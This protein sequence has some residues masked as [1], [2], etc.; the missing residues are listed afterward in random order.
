MNVSKKLIIGF[1][2]AILIFLSLVV[3]K[4]VSASTVT[5]SAGPG[6]AIYDQYGNSL[7][8]AWSIWLNQGVTKSFTITPDTGYAIFSVTGCGG[9]LSGNTYTIGPLS[10]DCSVYASFTPVF[11]IT[12]SA[13]TGGTISPSGVV[14]VNYGAQQTFTV[15]ANT[16]YTYTSVTGCGGT[17]FTNIF[18]TGQITANCAVTATFTPIQYSYNTYV[19]S[20]GG[21]IYPSG[22]QAAYGA[23]LSLIVTPATGYTISSV[24]GCGGILSGNTYTIGPVTANCSVY[25]QFTPLYNITASAGQG[26]NIYPSGSVTVNT[27]G[28]QAFTVTPNSGYTISSVTGCGGTLSGSTYEVQSKRV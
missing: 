27:G 23:I 24:T 12:A 28:T 21:T 6:G 13:G 2:T 14:T 16:G 7:T 25:A 22:G 20:G 26:G 8:P 15:A 17:L 1:F 18:T 9:I 10:A 5:V 11:N 4:D 19:S 3:S